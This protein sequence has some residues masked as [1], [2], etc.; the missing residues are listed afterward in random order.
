MK[1]INYKQKEM[2]QLTDKENKSHE[3]QK[4][5]YICKKEFSAD[6]NNENAFKLYYKV[7][8]HCYYTWK[9][10]E[11]ALSICNLRYKPK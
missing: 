6:E 10:R 9:F 2:I 8:H 1:I 7:R 3:K 11:A 4:V 5:C